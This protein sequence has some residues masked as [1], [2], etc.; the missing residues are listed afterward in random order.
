MNAPTS[1]RLLAVVALLTAASSLVAQNTY[2]THNE[3][4]AAVGDAVAPAIAGVTPA[5]G[6]TYFATSNFDSPILDQ[7]G[8]VLFRGRMTGGTATGVDDRAY[9]LGR[10]AADLRMVVRAGDQAPGLPAGILLRSS[11]STSGSGG[12]N[13]APRISPYNE[14]L[15]FQ[16]TLY[17]PVTPANTVATNDTALFWGQAGSLLPLAREGDAVPFLGTGETY[18]PFLA[19]SLQYAAIDATGR[20]L[21]ECQLLGGVTTVANDGVLL[22][23]VP[24]SLNIVS[25]EG[26]VHP[27]GEVVIPSSGTTQLTFLHQMNELGQVLHEVRYSVAAPSTATTANDR[28]LAI[29]TPGS[30][31][32]IIAREGQQA[33][34]LP[35]GVLFA[36]PVFGWNAGIGNCSFTRSG[37]TALQSQLDGGGTT[38]GVDDYAM[39]TGGIGGLNLVYRRGAACP[40]LSGGEVFGTAGNSSIT[41]TE[42]GMA[43]IVS[44]A[45]PSVTTANDS[46]L[47]TG[48][49][50]NLQMLAREGNAVPGMP[51]FTFQQITAGTNS[52]MMNDRGHVMANLG[53]TDGATS[54]NVLFAYTPEHG[55]HAQLELNGAHTFT[56]AAGT[57]APTGLSSAQGFNSSDGSQ[58]NFNNQGDF[59]FKP[60]FAAPMTAAV[61]RGHLGSMAAS[62]SA[63]SAAGGTQTFSLDAGPSH[64]F[65][66]HWI[67]ASST[68][69]RPGFLSPLGPQTVPLNFDPTWTQLSI[70]LAN[71]V[72]WTNTL[73]FTDAQGKS[74]AS[75]TLPPGIPGM[76]GLTLHHA[77]L[78]FN[79]S[80]VSTHAT[81]P[82]ALKFF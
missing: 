82:S 76:A 13:G 33:P 42:A 24:G 44:L 30:G 56:T 43:F 15:F 40:G 35:V 29:Y 1:N 48:T 52:P 22:T 9:F 28:A 31:N 74:T 60:G 41:C 39:Y 26:D 57:G 3:L 58:S 21:F 78:L 53:I 81:E 23:G 64:A 59:V 46:S 17:D 69:T 50:G 63:V 79:N 47:W 12:L 18:G 55:M 16:S 72:V 62:P 65:E 70:D 38:V 11:S 25:R 77:G 75:F 68:G 54:R 6:S 20:V 4:V 7:N 66:W 14:Y 19:L 8:S 51:G 71:S 10:S 32:T 61:F 49:I 80:L 37:V 2:A 73:W 45:G 34:G 67:V 36:T 5:L 27:G